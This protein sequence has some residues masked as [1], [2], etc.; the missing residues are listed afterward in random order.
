MV[1]KM[2]VQKL[3]ITIL[4]VV[5]IPLTTVGQHGHDAHSNSNALEVNE[6]KNDYSLFNLNAEWTNHRNETISLS[7]FKGKPVIIVM[8]YGNC[9]QV[10]PIL[11]R[12]A[13]RVYRGVDETLQKDIRV[14]AITFDPENDTP[15]RLYNYAIEKELNLPEWHFVTGSASN[16]RQIAML[17]GVEYTKKSDGHF[18]HSNLVTVL[19]GD[20]MIA[21]RMVGLNQPI[22]KAVEKIDNYLK[23][24]AGNTITQH[25][26]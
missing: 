21:E 9:T 23:M 10:C 1:D 22:E 26:H 8:Y 25:S 18:A 12:D 17:L 7:E 19:D 20:G 5:M 2:N 14:L 15:E 13:N 11:I 16:I 6:V 3:Y 24:S 4:F